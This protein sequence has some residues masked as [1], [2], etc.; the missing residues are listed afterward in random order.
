MVYQG[1]SFLVS[2]RTFDFEICVCD[3][4][5][6]YDLFFYIAHWVAGAGN[7]GS[8]AFAESRSFA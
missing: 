3:H 5:A 6:S 1:K 7:P 2:S 4:P 8:V